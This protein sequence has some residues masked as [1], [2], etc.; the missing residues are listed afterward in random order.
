MVTAAMRKLFKTTAE[1]DGSLR[2]AGVPVADAAA[3]AANSKP[4]IWLETTAVDDEAAIALGAT[5]IGGTPDLPSGMPWPWRPPYPDH[6]VRVAQAQA[7]ADLFNSQDMAAVRAETLEGFR[8]VLPS[9]EFEGVAAESAKV[10]FGDS[11]FDFLVESARRT[12]EPAP[13]QFIAQVDLADVWAT[14]PVDPDIPHEG[15]LL[16]FYDTDHRPGGD[17]P[18]D[19]TGARL[20]YDLTPVCSLERASP[21]AELSARKQTA[22]FRPQRCVLH[23]GMWPP[24]FGS[25]EWNACAIKAKTEKTVEAWWYEAT[26]DGHDHRFGGHPLPIQ[27]DMRIECA[28]VTKGFDL[29]AW[30]EA[31][32]RLKSDAANWLMLLQIASDDRAGMMWG[33]VGN[34]YVWIHRNALRARRFEEARVIM[35]GY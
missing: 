12:E 11:Y 30:D 4:Y 15:R 24:Y 13:L 25:P 21:P 34:L 20:I 19:I 23:A 32:E 6:E 33:D 1:I 8:M 31:A 10:D 14:G 9:D 7:G 28:L 29:N 22:G 26:R 18:A 17:R 35:Q 27:G 3:L 16:L 5:K 2:A